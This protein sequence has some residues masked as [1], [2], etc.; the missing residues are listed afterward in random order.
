MARSSRIALTFAAVAVLLLTGCGAK[1]P[2]EKVLPWEAITPSGNVRTVVYQTYDKH[3][4]N[5]DDPF[6]VQPSSA[7]LDEVNGR[8]VLKLLT[9]DRLATGPQHAAIQRGC[10]LVEL[11]PERTNADVRDA[12]RPDRRPPNPRPSGT[13]PEGCVSLRAHTG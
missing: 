11:P 8:V 1:S 7:V 13:R 9:T 6:V 10:A 2:S 5:G 3:G 4:E 12:S